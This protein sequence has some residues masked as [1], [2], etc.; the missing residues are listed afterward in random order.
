M[1]RHISGLGVA[2]ALLAMSVGPAAAGELWGDLAYDLF[3]ERTLHDGADV[4]E[5]EMP[6]RAQDAAVVPVKLRN[7][8]PAEDPR[9]I[10][11]ITLVIEKNRH[12]WP[13][14]SK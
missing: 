3:G 4:L 7:L 11:H 5:L 6:A 14:S 12:P 8:L 10:R 2:V 9:Q 1:R 13:R